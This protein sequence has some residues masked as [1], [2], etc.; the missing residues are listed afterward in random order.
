MIIK[1]FENFKLFLEKDS[2]VYEYGCILLDLDIP[3]WKEDFLSQ[4]LEE[5]VYEYNSERYGL[6]TEPHCTILYGLHKDITDDQVQELF[7]G[8]KKSDIDI[9]INGM[10]CF[11]N[12]QYDVLKLNV[13]SKQLV[14]LNELAKTLPHTSNFPDYKPHIT[15]AY[16]KRGTGRKYV[17]PTF[18]MVV[19][20]IKSIT[21]SKSDGS[22]IKIPIN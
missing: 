20:S 11:Y 22:Q 17:K 21:Y 12:P 13:E 14:E 18:E 5:D 8:V 3:N 19:N 15:I 1:T 2:T 4:I 10:D 16:L 6:E 7:I 9:K